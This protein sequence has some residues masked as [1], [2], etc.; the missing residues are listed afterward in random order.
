MIMSRSQVKIVQVHLPPAV[1]ARLAVVISPIQFDDDHFGTRSL[2]RTEIF[3]VKGRRP[4]Q[5]NEARLLRALL[6]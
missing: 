6:S 3:G 1:R 2:T 5:L 4:N